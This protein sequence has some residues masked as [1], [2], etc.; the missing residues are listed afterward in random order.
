M[1]LPGVCASGQVHWYSLY[2]SR[3]SPF[4]ENKF[5]R[6]KNPYLL[7]DLVLLA[8]AVRVLVSN[9]VYA[10]AEPNFIFLIFGLILPGVAYFF[11]G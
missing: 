6:L 2:L 7:G 1:D 4:R 8:L 9:G 11:S 3:I 5:A 10:F